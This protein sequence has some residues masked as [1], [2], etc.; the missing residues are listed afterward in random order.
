[1]ENFR[2]IEA[3]NASLPSS[4]LNKMMTYEVSLGLVGFRFGQDNIDHISFTHHK[5]IGHN[6]VFVEF[7]DFLSTTFCRS[8]ILLLQTSLHRLRHSFGTQ[9]SIWNH[10]C[11]KIFS[12]H[13]HL[14]E[15]I[16]S[17]LL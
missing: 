12:L 9:Y 16:I 6:I 8:H 14:F 11:A 2:V 13:E 4:Y 10:I 15:F 3:K 17:N 5:H 7:L 1:M